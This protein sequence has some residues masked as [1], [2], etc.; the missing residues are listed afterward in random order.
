VSFSPIAIVGRACVLPGAFTPQELWSAALEGRDLTGPAPKGRWRI[1]PEN[2]LS[3]PGASSADRTWSDRGG[4]VDDEGFKARFDPTGFKVPAEQLHGLDPLFHWVLHTAR[5]ALRDGTPEADRG[6]VGAI[7]GNLSFPSSSM[8]LYAESVWRGQGG[9][10][11]PR[12]RFM[13]GLP[14]LL[15][16]RALGLKAGAFALDAACASSLYAIKLACDRLHDG[17]ADTMLAGAVNRADDLFI[18]VGFSALSALSQSGQSRPFHAD[19]DGL[20]PAE[21]AGFVALRRL[22]DA[23]R[24]GDTIFGVIRG[25]GLSNDGRGRGLLAPSVEGQVRAMRQAYEQAELRPQDISLLECH[26]TGTVVG[27]ATEVRSIAKVFAGGP[28]VPLASLKSNL[29][30]LIT[31]AGVAGLIKVLQSLQAET[32]APNRGVDSHIK[33]LDE[34]PVSLLQT[35]QPWVCK[36]VRRAGVSAFGF[37]GNNAH[38]I[39]EQYSPGIAAPAVRARGPKPVAVVGIGARVADLG[40]ASQLAQAILS[41]SSERRG[42][43]RSVDLD[44]KGLKF[45]PNDLKASLAQQVALLA[46]AREAVGDLALPRERTGIF[47]GM[48][49][50]PEVARYG[51]RWRLAD[52]TQDWLPA[53]GLAEARDQV[54]PVLQAAGVVGTMPNIPANRLNSQFDLGGPSF[55]ISAEQASGV[56]ALEVAARALRAHELD[57]AIV[58]AVDLSHEAVHEASAQDCLQEHEAL[59]GDAAIVLVL[60]RAEDA[61]EGVLAHIDSTVQASPSQPGMS[62]AALS[63]RVGHAHAASGLLQVAA[64][65]LSLAHRTSFEGRP[66]LQAQPSA[67][68]QVRTMLGAEQTVSLRAAPAAVDLRSRPEILTFT[69]QAKDILRQLDG[70]QVGSQ[71]PCRLAVVVPEP[72]MRQ[73][74]LRRARA[75]IESGAP[76]GPGVHYFAA[77][78]AGEMAFVYTGAGAAY[79]GMGKDLLLG[80]PELGA[81]LSQRYSGAL[82]ALRWSIEG[83]EDYAPEPLEKLWGASAVCQLHAELSKRLELSAQAVIG[84]SSGESNSLFASGAWRDLDDMVA[85]S[86]ACGLFGARDDWAVWTVLAPISEIRQAISDEPKVHLAI[87]HSDADGVISGDKQ[88]CLRVVAR[89]GKHRAHRLHYDLAVHVPEVEAVRAQWM[90]LHRRPVHFVPGLRFYSNGEHGAYTPSREACAKMITAQA[91]RTLNF[92]RTIERAYEDGVRIFV[93]HGP[94][95][96]CS[97]WIKQILGDRE[98]LVLSYDHKGQ[99]LLSV[100]D[101]AACLFAAGVPLN[102]DPL[103]ATAR[104]APH[105]CLQVPAH[106]APVRWP[107][108]PEAAPPPYREVEIVK[109]LPPNHE[110]PQHMEPAPALPPALA[111]DADF[112]PQ[113]LQPPAPTPASVPAPAAVHSASPPAPGMTAPAASSPS[114]VTGPLAVAQAYQAQLAQAHAEFVA[115]QKAVHEQ[116]LAMRQNATMALLQAGAATAMPAARVVPPTPTTPVAV[117]VPVVTPAAPAPVEPV[118]APV[119]AAPMPKAVPVAPPRPA[120]ATPVAKSLPSPAHPEVLPGLKLSR[121]DLEVHASGKISTIYGPIFEAQDGYARQVRMP[122]PPLL[123]ADRVTGLDAEPGSMKKG[124]I[125][126]ETDVTEDAWYLNAGYMPAGIMIE[127]GQADLM[128]ISYLGIDL[129]NKGERV[130]RLL[131]CDLTYVDDLPSIGDTLRYDIHVD[132]HAQQGEQR[133]FFFH[134]DCNVDGQPKLLVRNGQAGFFTDAELDDSAGVIWSPQTQKIVEQPRLDEP[135]IRCTRSSFT[136]EQIRAFAEGRPWQ[137]FGPGFEHLHTHVRTPKIQSGRMTFLEQITDY[138]LQGGPWGRGYLKAETKISPDDWFF[139]GHFKNDPC[140]PGTLMFE[141]CLQAMSIYLAGMGFTAQRDGWRFQPRR[142]ET[143]ALKCRG[144][145]TPTSQVLTY[146]IFVEE[147]V[148]GPHPTLYADVLCTVDGLKAFH[149]RRLA[150]ELVPDWPITSQP[151]LLADYIEQKPVARAGDF[152]FDYKSL[153]ACAWGKPSDAFGDMYKVFDGVR[154]VARLPGPPYHFMTRVTHIEGQIGQCKPGAVIE[155]EYDIPED[156]W[157]FDANGNRTMPF[158]VLLEAAL[159]PCGWLASFVGS[160]LTVDEDL[161]F[162]NLDGTGDLKKELQSDAGTLRTRVKITNISQTAGMII[163]SFEVECLLEDE[164]VYVMNT[165]FGF[166]PGVALQNQKGLP[167]LPEHVAA[168]EAESDYRVDLTGQPE[169]YCKGPL[170]L[171]EPMLLML[172]RVTAFDP[173]GGEAGLGTLRAEK[174]VDPSEWFFKAHFFQ[175]PVQPGSLGIEAMIQLLQFYMLETEMHAGIDAPRFEP[176][177][178]G[179]PMTWKYR[180][181]VVPSNE[182]ISTTLEVVKT[183]RDELGPYAIAKASLWVDG[184]RIYEASNL[185]MRIVSGGHGPRKKSPK[186]ETLDPEVDSWLNDHCPTFTVPALPM[187]SM[188]DR[189]AAAASG[190]VVGLRDVRVRR[191]LTIEGP[192]HLRTE[193]DGD[194]VRLLEAEDEIAVGRVLSGE[195]DSPPAAWPALSGPP[196]PLP[197]ED[198]RLFHGPAFQRLTQLIETDEGSSSILL[199]DPG[200]VPLGVLNQLLLDAATHGIRHETED[201]VTYPAVITELDVYGTTP[202]TGEVRCEMRYDGHLGGPNFPAYRVQ[203]ITDAGVWAQ[204][205]LVEAGFPKG[206]LGQAEPRDRR[207]FLRDR[208]FVPGLGL[209]SQEQGYT[210]VTAADVTAT[211]WLPGTVRALYGSDDLEAIA[212][213]SHCATEVQVHPG[214]LPEGTPLTCYHHEVQVAEEAVQVRSLEAPTLDISPVK[215]FWTEWFDRAPWPVEDLYYGLIEQFVGKVVLQDPEGFERVRGKSVLYLANHQVGVES[216]V[217]SILASGLS[218][219]PTVTL[220]KMEHKTT[221]LGRLIQHSFDY[222]GVRDPKVI[223]F[224]D[225]E[226]RESLPRILGELAVEMTGPGRSV[227]VHIEG[228][229]SLQCRTPVQKMSGAFIDMALKVGAPIVPV[230]FTGALPADPLDARREFPVGMGRQDIWLGSPMSPQSLAAAHYGERKRRVIDAINQLGPSN[231]DEVPTQPNPDL[232]GAV[233]GNMQTLGSDHEHATLYEVLRRCSTPCEETQRLLQSIQR[234]ETCPGQRPEDQWLRVLMQRLAP[235]AQTT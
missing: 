22:A 148:A 64:T 209:E 2:I 65:A 123:L 70:G 152:A 130:Y 15:L 122:E 179:L 182:C 201:A 105:T 95:R 230:R 91:V 172:D 102:L 192:V 59:G 146:E 186:T 155:L 66:V 78:V 188:V 164:V 203:L 176:I 20:L 16:E 75:H 9:G 100:Y 154:R 99:G 184:R 89:I 50:D 45:P 120:V 52:L 208:R 226:D 79:H 40:N 1:S 124:T 43:M 27:D 229:R 193:V 37:G 219:V 222:P 14:A 33:A 12:N 108:R 25:V 207:S 63:A 171:P 41:D 85:E 112:K 173:K 32:M 38:L 62:G 160:A 68:V 139:E 21:G 58:A 213:K 46:A 36:G 55:V 150:L 199:A 235:R 7:F 221:W 34:A 118:A 98:A 113:E 54:V 162:R 135:E 174:D 180:G 153:L 147:V 220:A 67:T 87:I 17:V 3:A 86:E 8:S 177:Q 61:G 170:R 227:M 103:R 232:E 157:Y 88:A 29:G 114:P 211:D 145:V 125:W 175:D 212:R 196:A 144:Q 205:R 137:C 76:A 28:E 224:F 169:K 161:S 94:Q 18:H 92:P 191:W 117:H 49:C 107:E 167:K 151:E 143:Y 206:R 30:H 140:M 138:D 202:T 198:G 19:A 189:L 142:N 53:A 26:A 121:E 204:F 185:G 159:Q 13:S 71:G 51:A 109:N 129:L 228:T 39:V 197:Y 10:P 31:A 115:R 136:T 210:Q 82:G 80:L 218:K 214:L 119:Q 181:Q 106:P 42:P 4:Y 223:T 183:G 234:G 77:P 163:E 200:Q 134:Y 128:L 104:V 73:E 194:K 56:R 156:A 44:L 90:Q 93:E 127:S 5:A 110:T 96:A 84:Y 23:E 168:L 133:L 72:A 24:D 187:M 11:D 217:F 166:F 111:F 215:H 101:T 116:F 195:F 60:Q 141:G 74:R 6:R 126:T 233:Q 131:G 190:K 81:S 149:A 48:G 35:P 132:G 216:L 57:V 97:R 69:G 47:V 83:P 225:R 231:A 158:A 178:T 165:V